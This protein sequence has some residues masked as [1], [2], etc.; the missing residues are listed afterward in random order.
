MHIDDRGIRYLDLP[1]IAAR[2]CLC[3]SLTIAGR[4]QRVSSIWNETFSRVCQ[5]DSTPA[6]SEELDS[7]LCF[8]SL[9]VPRNGRLVHVQPAGCTREV[10][11]FSDRHYT[12]IL[13][14]VS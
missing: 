2:D 6:P 11:F 4:D 5:F 13:G 1:W 14:Q 12:P 8:Q 10:Q 9:D 7:E 3:E